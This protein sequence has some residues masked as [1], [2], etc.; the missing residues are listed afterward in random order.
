MP[1]EYAQGYTSINEAPA[2][3]STLAEQFQNA[4]LQLKEFLI[5]AGTGGAWSV[6]DSCDSTATGASDLWAAAA[7]VVR[8]TGTHSWIVLRSPEGFMQGPDGSGTGAQSRVWLCIDARYANDYQV[9]FSLHRTAPTGGTT[10]AAPT[11]SGQLTWSTQQILRTSLAASRF[12]GSRDVRGQFWWGISP[13]ASSRAAFGMFVASLVDYPT[14]PS[15]LA[16]NAAG[17]MFYADSARGAFAIANFAGA[18]RC[19]GWNPDGTASSNASLAYEWVATNNSSSPAI[20]GSG[21][22]TLN[23]RADWTR[24]RVWNNDTT[25]KHLYG[26]IPDIVLCSVNNPQTEVAPSSGT[27]ERAVFG[28]LFVPADAVPLF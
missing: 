12:H 16:Y 18:E 14:T 3:E 26:R 5:A 28:D 23:S 20:I 24:L 19:R 22:N 25:H 17:F 21:G 9:E 2:A 8:G 10:S 7:D 27:P 4:L 15:D 1:T 6:T 11:S 13:N